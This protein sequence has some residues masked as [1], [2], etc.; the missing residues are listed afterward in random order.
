MSQ[1]AKPTQFMAKTW[2]FVVQALIVG[3][4]ASFSLI[5][6]PL[7]LFGLMK[8]ADDTPATEAGIALTAFSVPLLLY[9]ALVVYNLRARRRPLL[10]LCREGIEI[11]QIGSSWLDGI[12]L[13]P[14]LI[15]I[16]W[17]I[18]STQGFKQRVVRVPWRCFQDAW[19]SGP[20]MARRLTIVASLSL[21]TAEDLPPGSFLTDQV[22]LPEVMFS[23]PLDQIAAAIKWNADVSMDL[24]HLASWR[25]IGPVHA[26][27]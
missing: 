13:I 6:G 3:G 8:K 17:L 20:P 10:R 19:V 1:L 22:V 27:Q 9:M 15:R 25:D 5:F 7:F 11:V 16:A 12:P 23:T 14:G 4:F 24:E 26:S 18:L 2:I 21:A